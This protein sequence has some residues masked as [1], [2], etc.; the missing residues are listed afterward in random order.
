MEGSQSAAFYTLEKPLRV[1]TSILSLA[2][3]L[4]SASGLDETFVDG[5]NLKFVL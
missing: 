2:S 1:F 4:D 3:E 5:G